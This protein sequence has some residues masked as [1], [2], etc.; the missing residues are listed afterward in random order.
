MKKFFYEV[1]DLGI[2]YLE[3]LSHYRVATTIIAV[4]WLLMTIV[5]NSVFYGKPV[6]ISHIVLRPAWAY[7]NVVCA[8]CVSGFT[9]GYVNNK[10]N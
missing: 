3:L 7:I 9:I 2:W 5:L 8:G 10:K 1:I 6:P 4:C